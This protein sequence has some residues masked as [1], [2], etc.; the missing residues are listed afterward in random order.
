METLPTHV[1]R[2]LVVCGVVSVA[3]VLLLSGQISAGQRR[4]QREILLKPVN[5]FRVQGASLVDAILE[6]GKAAHQPFGIEYVDADA[7]EKPVTARLDHGAL[8]QALAAIFQNHK[9]YSWHVEG[10]VVVITSPKSPR[11]ARESPKPSAS[12]IFD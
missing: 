1:T 2:F 4:E 8:E 3:G 5:E 7:L 10:G 12:G 6:L 11:G 9:E